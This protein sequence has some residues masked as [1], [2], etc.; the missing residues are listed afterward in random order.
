M[1][2]L[3][4]LGLVLLTAAGCD[5]FAFE[6][7]PLTVDEAER[8]KQALDFSLE[9]TEIVFEAYAN[10]T[11]I[12]D[13]RLPCEGGVPGRASGFLSESPDAR[14]RFTI[15]V[16]ANRC[17]HFSVDLL[18]SGSIT[19]SPEAVSITS[20]L[21]GVAWLDSTWQRVEF[22]SLEN[23][24][25]ARLISESPSLLID[26]NSRVVEGKLDVAPSNNFGVSE[27][28]FSE[29]AI[30]PDFS[31]GELADLYCQRVARSSD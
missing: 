20:R 8:A 29:A 5:D 19:S 11:P 18:L 27:C 28:R 6:P 16:T 10:E 23:T 12:L 30:G 4:F 17:P 25:S 13:E 1:R 3:V 7:A 2:T 9:L 24:L 31:A 15:E 22:G 14:Q 26:E 21:S